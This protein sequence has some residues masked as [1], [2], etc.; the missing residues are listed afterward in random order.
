[1]GVI[2]WNIDGASGRV[3]ELGA[4]IHEHQPDAVFVQETKTERVDVLQE[5]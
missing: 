3:R 1:M 5:A 4:L 2:Q